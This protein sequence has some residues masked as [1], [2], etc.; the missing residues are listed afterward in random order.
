M[1][2]GALGRRRRKRE[3]WQQML[4]QV[5]IF[6]KK[7]E[8]GGQLFLDVF[9]VSGCMETLYFRWFAEE[10]REKGVETGGKRKGK[11]ILWYIGESLIFPGGHESLYPPNSLAL[12]F[13]ERSEVIFSSLEKQELGMFC[14]VSV[15]PNVFPLQNSRTV[16]SFPHPGVLQTTTF[17]CIQLKIAC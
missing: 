17:Q 1:Y 6:K 2:W 11:R 15:F 5:P 16:C 12:T 3:D 13:T 9:T 7:E 8:K 10:G 14:R 4:G